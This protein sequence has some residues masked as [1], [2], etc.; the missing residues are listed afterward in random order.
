M[1]SPSSIILLAAASVAI[2]GVRAE[3]STILDNVDAQ[4][5][6]DEAA[7]YPMV[8]KVSGS[9][10]N[11]SGVLISNRWVLTA[12][13]VADFKTGGTF[14]VDGVNYLIQSYFTHP[15]HG[16]FST[17]YD[18]GLLYLST[19]VPGI[20]AA[21]LLSPA[22]YGS[23]LGREATWVGNGLTGVGSDDTRGTNEMRA[24]TNVID[25]VTP[26]AG[27]PAPSFFSDFDNPDGTGNSLDSD[28]TP[29]RL[30]GNVT[31][32]DS[33]G[34][35]FITMNGQRYLVGINSYTGGFAPGLNSKYGSLSGAADLEFFQTWI[36]QN[37]G[38]SPVPEPQLA[39]LCAVGC[40]F[41]FMRR[42]R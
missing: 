7:L 20:E 22:A 18:V 35:V 34:G 6:R 26:F 42:R 40:L 39:A 25:G 9:G 23:L 12:G 10:L 33:G 28:A 4:N 21:A 15:S 19:A 11:G 27:L 3:A 36:F 30:E 24:F 5:Y 1:I 8:G 31:P 32:G 41:G 29:T 16:I 38:I 13:H 2:F 17:T 14:N 37:T